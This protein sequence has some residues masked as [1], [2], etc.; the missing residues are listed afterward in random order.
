MS[1]TKPAGPKTRKTRN[2]ELS[3]AEI[4]HAAQ[5]EFSSC[6]FDGARVSRIAQAAGVNINL[7]Y[8]YFGNKEAL[9]I[10]VME[11]AYITIR[12]HHK[13]LELLRLDPVDAMTELVRAT[14][15]LFADNPHIIGLLSS[16][17]M[18]GAKHIRQSDQIRNLYNPLLE[19]I[20][21]TL[22]RGESKGLFRSGI[23]AVE[24]FI[25]INAECYFY[26]SN[27]HTL[28]FIL[29]RDLTSAESRAR[30]K[31]HVVDVILSF[32]RAHGNS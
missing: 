28:G 15:D 9:F 4:L 6:G 16:E 5:V 20:R 24:L 32:L 18:H 1:N 8:H 29:H 7:V 23:D 10:A 12:T 17:N 2:S 11:A 26:L 30:R 21:E 27:Q 3:K 13:Y 22:D 14:F 25:S 31:D 19:T